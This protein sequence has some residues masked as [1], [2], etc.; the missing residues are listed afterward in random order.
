MSPK[1]PVYVI[2]KGRWKSRLTARALEAMG[3]PYSIVVEPQER[4]A[5][6]AVID[7]AKVLVLPFS[8]LGQGSIPARN[9]VWDHATQLGA[10]RHW[11]MDDNIRAFYRLH[12]NDKLRLTSGTA[13]RVAEQFVDRYTNV[14]MAGLH[15]AHIIR[16]RQVWPPY[17]L[18][19]RVYSC[20]LLT[21]RTALRWRGRYNEDTDLSLRFLKAGYCTILFLAFLCDKVATMTMHGGNTDQLYADD[22]RLA[23]AQS[24]VR[25]HPDVTRIYFRWG[26]YQHQVNYLPFKGN[27]LELRPDITLRDGH[28]EHG[29]LILRGLPSRRAPAANKRSRKNVKSRAE[30]YANGAESAGRESRPP[31]PAT[32]PATEPGGTATMPGARERRRPQRV[33]PCGPRHVR[34]GPSDA[35]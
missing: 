16:R 7:P 35:A 26:R 19:T 4:D 30:T 1:Y 34:G 21:N 10:E 8:N 32:R 17:F 15:Y 14:P 13:L 6:A 12:H 2:S 28:N 5:Y 11:I 24:L 22:G 20:I 9:W 25:Q 33:E 3:V 27:R 29:M 18:N 31:P 23:M